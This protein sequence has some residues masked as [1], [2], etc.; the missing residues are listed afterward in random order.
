MAGWFKRF[1]DN[2]AKAN[3][4]EFAGKKMDC[5]ELHRPKENQI[6][7]N[8]SDTVNAKKNEHR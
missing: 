1:L 7:N 4:K 8:Y 2:L 6:K 5:C 3:E